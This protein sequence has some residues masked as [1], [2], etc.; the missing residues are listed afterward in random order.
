MTPPPIERDAEPRGAERR[1]HPRARAEWP[2]TILLD[3]GYHQAT[4]RD[5]SASGVCF[6]IDRPVP[7]M[8]LLSLQIDLPGS[9]PR[10]LRGEGVVVRSERIASAVDH[11]EVALFFH[12]LEDDDRV[13]LESYVSET[14][15]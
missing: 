14:H 12:A 9:T 1:Q 5:V 7:E 8:S 3:D 6:H 4:L 10:K 2:I 11:Y 13:A 15:A